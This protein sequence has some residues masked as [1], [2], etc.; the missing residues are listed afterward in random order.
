MVKIFIVIGSVRR[1]SESLCCSREK[2]GL[3]C[4]YHGLVWKSRSMKCRARLRQRKI[5]RVILRQWKILRGILLLGNVLVVKLPILR[6]AF[7]I[8]GKIALLTCA[9]VEDHREMR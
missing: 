5:L 7:P 3:L 2:G 9:F 4:G 8:V 6:N 1:S